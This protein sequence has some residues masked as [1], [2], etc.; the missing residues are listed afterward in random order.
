MKNK[1]QTTTKSTNTKKSTSSNTSTS[2]GT[3]TNVSKKVNNKPKDKTNTTN[4]KIST[5]EKSDSKKEKIIIDFKEILKPS[6][7]TTNEN[8]NFSLYLE[9]MSNLDKKDDLKTLAICRLILSQDPNNTKVKEL[10]DVIYDKI[11]ENY[12]ESGELEPPKEE[13]MDKHMKLNKDGEYEYCFSDESED[14]K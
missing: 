8:V 1:K 14:E 10:H 5:P 13:K 12:Y 9:L 11:K 6:S 3:K 4:N 7:I 2:S